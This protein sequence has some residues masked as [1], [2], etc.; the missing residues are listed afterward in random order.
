[1]T[2]KAQN[3]YHA[4][5]LN[6]IGADTVVHPERD[7]GRR[8]AH[9]VASATVLDY[10]ELSDEHS[11]VEIK[12]SETMAGQTLI[13]LDIRAKFGINIIAIKRGKEIIV[14]PDPDMGLEF[15][16]ILIMIGHDNDLTR[17]EKKMAH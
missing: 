6:K 5:I 16:D 2:A 8:I 10:L 15:D 11:I 13:D 9:N 14:A 1:M 17:F 12:A 3:D 7:M 4:K